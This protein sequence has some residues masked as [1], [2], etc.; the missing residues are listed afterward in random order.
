MRVN[1]RGRYLCGSLIS[2]VLS[3]DAKRAERFRRSFFRIGSTRQRA[4]TNRI[5]EKGP[6]IS[7]LTRQAQP[8]S[9]LGFGV[10]FAKVQYS[11]HGATGEYSDGAAV[12]HSDKHQPGKSDACCL[13]TSPCQVVPFDLSKLVCLAL[14]NYDIAAESTPLS[15]YHHHHALRKQNSARLRPPRRAPQTTPKRDRGGPRHP[16]R[17]RGRGQK[18]KPSDRRVHQGRTSATKEEKRRQAPPSWTK[19]VRH[20]CSSYHTFPPP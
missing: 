7:T 12:L 16:T 11:T 1:S 4:L 6:I 20:V 13:A 18:N 19:R 2:F 17:P 9:P 8:G 10:G 5:R 14:G 3:E 15:S